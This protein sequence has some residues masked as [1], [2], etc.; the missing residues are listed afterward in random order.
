MRFLGSI[1]VSACFV[2][3]TVQVIIVNFPILRPQLYFVPGRDIPCWSTAA[4]ICRTY[5]ASSSRDR[6]SLRD[7]VPAP[8]TAL[9]PR[10]F[11]IAYVAGLSPKVSVW[12]LL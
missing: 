1:S 8:S 2:H 11:V 12:A 5:L 4:Y 7:E 3:C 10:K 9:A 6:P